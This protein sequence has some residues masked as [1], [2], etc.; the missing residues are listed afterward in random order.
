LV[1]SSLLLLNLINSLM[2]CMPTV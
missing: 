1:Q 2:T